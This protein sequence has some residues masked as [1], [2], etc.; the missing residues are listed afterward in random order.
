MTMR[1]FTALVLFLLVAAGEVDAAPVDTGD[2]D[3]ITQGFERFFTTSN[4][5]VDAILAADDYETFVEILYVVFAL[6]LIFFAVTH[7]IHGQLGVPEVLSTCPWR[8]T[9][10]RLKTVPLPVL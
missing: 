9:N 7:Y 4:G 1:L 10:S 5:A 8:I 6:I 3:A 2:Y